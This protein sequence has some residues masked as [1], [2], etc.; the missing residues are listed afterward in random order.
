MPRPQ[1]KQE[2]IAESRREFDAL[3]ETVQSVPPERRAQPGPTPEWSVKD[4]LAHLHAWHLMFLGWYQAGL[5]GEKPAV[6]AEGYNW[7]QLDALNAMLWQQSRDTDYETV[8]AQFKDSFA[9]VMAAVEERSEQDL[10][11]PKVY[12]W[13]GSTTL[14]GYITPNTSSHYRWARELIRKW[15]K[16]VK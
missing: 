8:L 3:L 13:T 1:T 7:K 15:V 2:I 5:R 11:A 4:L 6:P 9:Q 10:F 16:K 12:P 14:A